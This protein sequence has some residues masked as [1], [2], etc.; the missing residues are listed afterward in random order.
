MNLRSNVILRGG[1]VHTVV[2][3]GAALETRGVH[4]LEAESVENGAGWKVV[5]VG[6]LSRRG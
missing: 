4:S 1:E 6:I 3:K 5:A 2:S